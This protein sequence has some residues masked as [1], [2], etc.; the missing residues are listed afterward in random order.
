MLI[1]WSVFLDNLLH[2]STC[3]ASKDNAQTAVGQPLAKAARAKGKADKILMPGN[4]HLQSNGTANFSNLGN[5]RL[6]GPFPMMFMSLG[7][8]AHYMSTI[9]DMGRFNATHAVGSLA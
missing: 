1:I 2:D 5:M 9:Y 6:F 8:A 4:L 3:S 7:C